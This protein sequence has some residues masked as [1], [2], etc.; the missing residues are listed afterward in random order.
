MTVKIQYIYSFFHLSALLN[1][2]KIVTIFSVLFTTGYLNKF[3][4]NPIKLCVLKKSQQNLKK[5][6]KKQ[7]SCKLL[8]GKYISHTIKKI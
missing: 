6:K 4:N 2:R 8:H 1:N 5:K 7:P 3:I